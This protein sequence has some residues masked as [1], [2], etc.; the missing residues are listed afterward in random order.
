MRK[1]QGA[2]LS[3]KLGLCVFVV[4]FAIMA[5]E[6]SG[7]RL[8]QPYFGDTLFTW[9]SSISV[10]LAA[11]GI[12]YYLGGLLSAS[13]AELR[14]LAVMAF[15]AALLISLIPFVSG[16]TLKAS[17]GFGYEL[18]PLV[19]CVLLFGLP[20]V[21]LGIVAPYAVKLNT[22][23]VE[24]VGSSAGNLYAISTFGGILGALLSG[25]LMI[26]YIGLSESFFVVGF[27]LGI[28]GVMLYGIRSAPVLVA[29]LVAAL[30]P[31]ASPYAGMNPVYQA[32]TPYYS[33][34][35]LN[36]QNGVVLLT[37]LLGIQT[38]KD[39][40]AL[41]TYYP[42]Q[43]IL[44]N[45]TAKVSALYLG[46]GGGTMAADLY[47]Y[48]NASI[49]IVEIDPVVI[50]VAHK[51]FGLND[52]GRIRIYNQ[53]ARSFLRSYGSRYNFIVLDTYGASQAGMPP[54]MVTIEAAAEMKNHLVQGGA[55]MI[56]V[57]SPLSGQGSCT[58]KS[59][60]KTFGSV[61]GHVYVFPLIPNN[62]SKVQNVEIIASE[63][64]YSPG[65]ILGRLNN[66]V[67]ANQTAWIESGSYLDNFSTTGCQILTDNKNPFE[68]YSA[69][70]LGAIK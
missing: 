48:Q 38:V 23:V 13:R 6:I 24:S 16:I 29:L 11:L 54:Q 35:V 22:R 5:V 59:V 57:V 19:A 9:T 45:G 61:F 32:D 28:T 46:L 14:V 3:S 21:L 12:G 63:S 40:S 2:R 53:D 15:T 65:Y 1:N 64:N 20:N 25:Y 66:S 50:S 58:F 37:S 51:Y 67:P 17:L 39:A 60:Y 62:L 56:N 52:S 41:N 8:L 27:A 68:V 69:Q 33:I 34:A 7:A 18:G 30:L 26:P 47:K 42:Y 36:S 70:T 4:G 31:V 55:V 49:D 10:I 43:R 44:Y